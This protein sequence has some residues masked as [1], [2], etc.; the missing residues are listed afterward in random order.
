M[1]RL[2]H[3]VGWSKGWCIGVYRLING[4]VHSLG[5]HIGEDHWINCSFQWIVPVTGCV[6]NGPMKGITLKILFS[7]CYR[8]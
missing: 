3:T 7:F 6:M 8:V 5:L 2:V 1:Y 4:Q